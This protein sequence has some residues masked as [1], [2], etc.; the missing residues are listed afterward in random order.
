MKWKRCIFQSIRHDPIDQF[1]FLLFGGQLLH[2]LYERCD[3]WSSNE[4]ACVA[5]DHLMKNAS[6]VEIG[7]NDGL[8]MSNSYFFE[9]FLGWRGLC[10]EANPHVYE[11]LKNNRP[12]CNNINA[13]IGDPRT[14]PLP[15]MSFFRKHNQEKYNT[16]IDWETGLS[17]IE[18]RGHK[19]ISSVESARKFASQKKISYRR[20]M[21]PVR[22]FSDIFSQAKLSD[23]AFMSLDV[24]G[25]EE[26]VL[27]SID[28]D[29]VSIRVMAI[30]TVTDNIT[31][32]LHAKGFRNLRVSL[33]LGDRIFVHKKGVWM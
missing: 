14:S 23:I 32:F 27:R 8:H 30:E 24:E 13:L 33:S 9:T 16:A 31:A 21:L 28:F 7:A 11:R 1:V 15:F 2:P 10:I 17:G 26:S 6:F 5:P 3:I 22:S 18:G 25:A 29:R 12:N 19:E 4:C 20:S